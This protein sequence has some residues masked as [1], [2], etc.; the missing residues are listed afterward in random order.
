MLVGPT[1]G[2]KTTNYQMLAHA[3]TA[4]KHEAKYEATHYHI[5]NPKAIT[6]D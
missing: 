1:G 2:G 4:L 6:M 5:L 3:Q